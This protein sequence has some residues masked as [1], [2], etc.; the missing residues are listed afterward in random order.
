MT[1]EETI[2]RIQDRFSRTL[3]GL[4]E[5]YP[6]AI[7]R[8]GLGRGGIAEPFWNALATAVAESFGRAEFRAKQLVPGTLRRVS[9]LLGTT[10]VEPVV[11]VTTL[12]FRLR[13]TQDRCRVL[14]GTE[15]RTDSTAND[16]SCTFRTTVGIDVRPWKIQAT[17][18]TTQLKFG[19]PF[20]ANRRAALKIELARTGTAKPQSLRRLRVYI[21]AADAVANQLLEA[22]F[23]HGCGAFVSTD[24]KTWNG[25]RVQPVGFTENAQLFK[26]S[27]SHSA[28]L[29]REFVVFPRKHY[30]F[31]LLD[32]DI[33]AKTQNATI[34]LT[35]QIMAKEIEQLRHHDLRLNCVPAV[36]LFSA[37]ADAIRLEPGCTEYGVTLERQP[38]EV[39]LFRVNTVTESGTNTQTG[40]MIR[41]ECVQ[42][43][44]MPNPTQGAYQWHM[45]RDPENNNPVISTIRTRSSRSEVL[46]RLD[47]DVICTDAERA[48]QLAAGTRLN[49]VSQAGCEAE[50]VHSPTGVFFPPLAS[51]APELSAEIAHAR[52]S[53]MGDRGAAALVARLKQLLLLNWRSRSGQSAPW[54]P[55]AE[56]LQLGIVK[57]H[58]TD[59]GDIEIHYARNKYA[60]SAPWLFAKIVSEYLCHTAGFGALPTVRTCCVGGV[61]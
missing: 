51:T 39:A 41:R 36:N 4:A 5:R 44:E 20:D 52:W 23:E 47:L 8:T 37:T 19:I 38:R 34:A 48:T 6:T 57:L 53:L 54:V 26:T 1:L 27:G 25:I 45:T 46:S 40:E 21:A 60:G 58:A 22:I 10:P 24:N 30:Y 12:E 11:P 2:R 9:E 14:A 31:D 55:M 59:R 15:L 13:P 61:A 29:V 7:A 35:F 56:D 32:L 18:Y 17:E 16:G 3:D 42:Q 49:L 33:S 50:L 43:L 28:Q